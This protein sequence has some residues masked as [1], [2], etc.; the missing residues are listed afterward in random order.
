MEKLLFYGM[1]GEKMCF[2]HVL[3]NAVD[4]ADAGREVKIVFEGASVR[5]VPQFE[6]ERHPLYLKAKSRGLIA[7][8]C[9]A[10][11]KAM[12]VYVQ[13]AA[14]GLPMLDDMSGHA[15]MKPFLDAGYVVVGM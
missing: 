3:M 5:L 15:G 10:C 8:V 4:L 13:N 11:S 7:G 1:T 9:L 14:S 12:D 2:L 6:Q